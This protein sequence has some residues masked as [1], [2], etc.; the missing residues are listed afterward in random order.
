MKSFQSM[1]MRNGY[2]MKAPSSKKTQQPSATMHG[3]QV[4]VPAPILGYEALN[5]KDVYL[6]N[7]SHK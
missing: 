6:N 1:S 5:N 7:G 3:P 2:K 4:G